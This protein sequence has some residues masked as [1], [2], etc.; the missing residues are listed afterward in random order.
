LNRVKK[1]NSYFF[2]KEDVEAYTFLF[3][4]PHQ[5]QIAKELSIIKLT[6]KRLNNIKVLFENCKIPSCD[7][8]DL[9]HSKYI[10]SY[11]IHGSPLIIH[12]KKLLQC[13]NDAKEVH[14]FY[15]HDNVSLAQCLDWA[16]DTVQLLHSFVIDKTLIKT[17][18]RMYIKRKHARK[19]QIEERNE[20]Q[21]LFQQTLVAHNLLMQYVDSCLYYE[22]IRTG[23]PSVQFLLKMTHH[24]HWL[25]TSTPYKSIMN[26]F[27]RRR[28]LVSSNYEEEAERMVTSMGYIYSY[29]GLE[30]LEILET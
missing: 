30:T 5:R 22:Y 12:I 24:K 1:G 26:K 10:H 16:V 7:Q 11:K 17:Q 28:V 14:D 8:D 15:G 20:R 4:G 13:Y 9:L 27:I 25:Y 3:V 21:L 19:K 6:T 2:L 29:K 18:A 23:N